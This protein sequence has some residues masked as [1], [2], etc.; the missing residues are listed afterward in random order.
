MFQF[1]AAGTAHVSFPFV[2]FYREVTDRREFR[3]RGFDQKRST[4]QP[5]LVTHSFTGLDPERRRLTSPEAVTT[6][7]EVENVPVIYSGP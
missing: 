4:R 7:G 3:S 6:S 2:F 5:Q 1:E